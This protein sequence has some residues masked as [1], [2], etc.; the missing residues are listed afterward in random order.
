MQHRN[1]GENIKYFQRIR[2][3][4]Y[5]SGASGYLFVLPA[6]LVIFCLV[7]YPFYVAIYLSLTNA[8]VGS[9]GKFIGVRNYILLLQNEAFLQTLQNSLIYTFCAVI[10]K[11]ILGMGLALL[12]NQSIRYKKFFRGA[13]L[14][15]WV[16]PNT[17]STLGWLW[18]F[19]PLF[20]VFNWI[21]KHAGLI[22]MDVPWLSNP[23][24]AMF[25]IIMVNVWRG[26]PFFA[27]TLLAGLVSIPQELFK[28][29]H[30]DGA[31]ALKCF[32]HITLPL[33]RPLI[34]IVIL[35]STI[36]T[37]SDFNIVY[38]LTRGGP[39]NMTHLLSTLSFQVGLSGGRLGQ[40]AAISLFMFPVLCIVVYFQL[41]TIRRG[42]S[43][44]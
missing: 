36:F 33:L 12:L 40:G 27:I 17:L 18:M 28:A 30:I 2:L 14:L 34:L 10:L 39:M 29:A 35:F 44:E 20:S 22:E 25:A 38:I 15:P 5:R 24:W 13:I 43:Y 7:A 19:D 11:I 42:A 32:V 9:A 37:I 8:G 41:K 1:A 3:D 23:Y 16:I 26:L 4:W 31:G 21:L 6:L